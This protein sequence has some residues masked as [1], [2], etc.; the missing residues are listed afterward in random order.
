MTSNFRKYSGDLFTNP[1]TCQLR[2][3]Y[4]QDI[5]PQILRGRT[6]A[7]KRVG[8]THHH[9]TLNPHMTE[10]GTGKRK[11]KNLEY[12]QFTWLLTVTSGLFLGQDRILLHSAPLWTMNCHTTMISF[13]HFFPC[14]FSSSASSSL[15]P[16]CFSSIF[17]L[18][19]WE[20]CC[21]SLRYFH[22]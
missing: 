11:G 16:S 3:Y 15:I 12:S 8:K 4:G 2:T 18:L 7:H 13:F 9:H 19:W 14:I 10:R 1:T 17:S 6:S 22:P 21:L 20:F 5:E